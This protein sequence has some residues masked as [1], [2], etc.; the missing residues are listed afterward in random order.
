MDDFTN[1]DL[2]HA[3]LAGADLTGVRWSL[4]ERSGLLLGGMP[5]PGVMEEGCA[6]VVESR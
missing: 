6:R 4:S 3:S 1:S 2:T 5:G